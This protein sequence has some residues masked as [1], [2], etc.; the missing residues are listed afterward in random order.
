MSEL[1]RSLERWAACSPDAISKGSQAQVF[2]AI[3]DAQHDIAALGRRIERFVHG[4]PAVVPWE[5]V[6]KLQGAMDIVTV[7]GNHLAAILIKN[8]GPDFHEK[9]PF[10]M[11][12]QDALRTLCATDNFDVWCCWSSIKRATTNLSTGEPKA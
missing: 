5:D 2:Y 8:L 9:W 1:S 6:E 7:G 10:D 3:K 11:D 12:P 4:S